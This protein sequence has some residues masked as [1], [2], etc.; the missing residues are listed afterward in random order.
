[1]DW[2]YREKTKGENAD[3]SIPEVITTIVPV[4]TQ[5]LRYQIS[6][7]I[8]DVLTMKNRIELSRYHKDTAAAENGYMIY[9]DI[10]YSPEKIPI[11]LAFRFA[12][13]ETTYNSRIYAYENDV[14]YAFSIPAYYNRGKRVYLTL[15]YHISDDIDLWLRYSQWYYDNVDVISSG[16]NEIQGHTKSE[17]KAQLRIRF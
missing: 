3:A 14:L 7:R 17:V 9:Q 10:N 8:N 1:M 13:F 6:Y 16:M 4:T 5:H 2:R 11:S 15:Q 12:L